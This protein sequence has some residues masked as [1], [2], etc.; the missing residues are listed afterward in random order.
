MRILY[1]LP[2]TTI[3]WSRVRRITSDFLERRRHEW[4]WLALQGKPYN[5]L[6]A[7]PGPKHKTSRKISAIAHFAIVAPDE[8][9]EPGIVISPQH[10]LGWFVTSRKGD[11]LGLMW[12][13]CSENNQICNEQNYI[14]GLV[15]DCGNFLV[16][17]LE[18]LQ[19][20][21]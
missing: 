16:N 7:M 2:W 18:L 8:L 13:S 10:N 6:H 5:Y 11:V 15:Q 12:N 21:A 4:K 19:S 1:G 3:L 20:Y 14:D 9:F 17:A